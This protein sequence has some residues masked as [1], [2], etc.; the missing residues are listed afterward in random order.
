MY[1]HEL[2]N[3]TQFFWDKERVSDKL[4]QV[5]EALGY[6]HGR[7]SMIGFD[8]QL[9]ATA[10]TITSDI[11]S[12]SQIEG[13]TLNARSV[14]SSVARRLGVPAEGVTESLSHDVEGIVSV[15]LDA[16]HNYKQPLSEERLLNWHSELFPPQQRR[17]Y[18]I[19]VGKYRTHEMQ[20]VSGNMGRERIHYQAPDA[21]RVSQEMQR[22]MQWFNDDN[23]AASP[24]KAAIAHFWFV[25][26]HPFD[27]GNGRLARALSD[28]LLARY[29]N[30]N[31]RY[32]SMS[33]Q[34]LHDRDNYYR[35]LERAQRGNGDITDW[36]LWFLSTLL[37]AV[38]SS[39]SIIG[40]V[41]QKTYFW[42]LHANQ[43]CTER[44][45]TVL[46]V[47]LSG[48]DG[49]LTAKNWAKIADVS[50]DTANRD[51][52]DLVQKG[53]L[54]AVQGAVR[55]VAYLPC[56]EKDN[57]VP[58]ENIRLIQDDKQTLICISYNGKDYQEQL[59]EGDLLSLRQQERT[60]QD[61][62]YKYFAYLVVL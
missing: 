5:T 51:I 47:F 50:T 23:I 35:E 55:N 13:I 15:E 1:I 6:M 44:Q 19:D 27:D 36:L 29:E 53:L 33:N 10:E 54:R 16:T 26:I 42:Q 48:Y 45:K 7:L 32:Y 4:M 24:L 46:N 11:V 2:D 25:C 20:V 60:L 43:P 18:Q 17:L 3:W 22:F 52:A 28:M 14:R 41:L 62:A 21:Q 9:K 8:E 31:L 58:F 38:K 37:T 40:N 30:S 39:D 34:I 49:K 12:T 61:L 59:T 57:T 56:F